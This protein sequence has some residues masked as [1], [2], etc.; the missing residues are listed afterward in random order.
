MTFRIVVVANY[1]CKLHISVF[2][3]DESPTRNRQKDLIIRVHSLSHL[4][5]KKTQWI[6]FFFPVLGEYEFIPNAPLYY[7]L[8]NCS[9]S[10]AQTLILMQNNI[11]VIC[12][13]DTWVRSSCQKQHTAQ[14]IWIFILITKLWKRLNKRTKFQSVV[15]FRRP[16]KHSNDQ[17]SPMGP[18]R[19]FETN[20]N[21]AWG[22]SGL[23]R[24]L[25]S[26]PDYKHR[27]I[28]HSTC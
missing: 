13:R 12:S 18:T 22:C 17:K 9:V 14:R 15:M 10:N 5:S 11:K 24:T 1:K 27:Y 7:T 2:I 4:Y 20:S 16:K 25:N 3:Q 21:L 8:Q 23:N 28:A 6:R 19:I 26:N